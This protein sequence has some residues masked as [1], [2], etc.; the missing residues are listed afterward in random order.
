VALIN[1]GRDEGIRR[2]PAAARHYVEADRSRADDYY[3]AEG[4]GVAR[5]FT[6]GDGRVTELA[7]LTGEAYETW[8]A[9][10]SRPSGSPRSTTR[11]APADGTSSGLP[12]EQATFGQPRSSGPSVC[13]RHRHCPASDHVWVP[14]LVWGGEHPTSVPARALPASTCATDFGGDVAT[15]TESADLLVSKGPC[16]TP[17]RENVRQHSVHKNFIR[18][19]R[20]PTPAN[21]KMQVNRGFQSCS[22]SLN[23]AG[24]VPLQ[25]LMSRLFPRSVRRARP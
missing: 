7:P 8:V 9:G 16:D 19:R 14:D 25:R 22:R 4:T 21:G 18:G 23:H 12:A 24:N 15:V 10:R 13:H 2:R 6:A 11:G 1:A 5:R 20:R 17:E 3:L